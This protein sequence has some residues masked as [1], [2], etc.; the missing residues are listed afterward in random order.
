MSS[1]H[2]IVFVFVDNVSH[3]AARHIDRLFLLQRR[4]IMEY[5]FIA[6]KKIEIVN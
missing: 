1:F 6:A 4:L 3:N 2:Q 5:Y